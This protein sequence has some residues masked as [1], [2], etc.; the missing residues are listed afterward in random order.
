MEYTEITSRKN[1]SVT[2]AVKLKDKK[3]RD[4]LG[5]FY[6]EGCK[7]LEEVISAE[8]PVKRLFFTQSALKSY[9]G[10]AE[11]CGK[12]CEKFL[13]SDEVYEKLTDEKAP[14]GLF[15]CAKIPEKLIPDENLL[16]EG[17]F[18]ILD[19]VQNP[20]NLGAIIRSA[21]ALRADKIVITHGCADPYGSKALRAAMGGIFKSKLYFAQSALEFIEKLNFLGCRTICTR[22]SEDSEKLGA[23]EFKPD[24]SIVIGN[25]GHGVS[26][27]TA[28][29]CTHCL[30][31]PMK[32]G[33]ESLNAACAAAITVWEMKKCSPIL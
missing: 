2:D 22:L 19:E 7:L 32:E 13:V 23:F 12:S 8:I 28:N 9:S 30:Y 29:A 11:Q 15:F 10:L 26:D 27:A 14:Q 16:K 1:P 4:R 3:N 25:E 6:A 5:M 21:F 18:V 20:Q 31:I 17:G 33:A 24:D